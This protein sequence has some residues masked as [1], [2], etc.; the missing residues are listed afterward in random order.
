MTSVNVA[1]SLPQFFCIGNRL[2]PLKRPTG[3]KLRRTP[4]LCS[5]RASESPILLFVCFYLILT[6]IVIHIAFLIIISTKCYIFYR[7]VYLFILSNI[8]HFENPKYT[9]VLSNRR[10]NCLVII[11]KYYKFYFYEF[12]LL[13]V[14]THL[15]LV[16]RN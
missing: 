11:K 15:Y 4:N 13:Q 9:T 10:C 14:P 3:L 5:Y 12:L 6:V 8:C 1:T 7:S 16:I 2:E